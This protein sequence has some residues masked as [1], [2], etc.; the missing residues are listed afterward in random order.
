M[1][2]VEPPLP[3]PVAVIVTPPIIAVE[4]QPGTPNNGVPGLGCGE[5]PPPPPIVTGYPVDAVTG[6]TAPG[7]NNPPAPPPP[8]LSPPPPP[9]P[10]IT[11]TCTAP[12]VEGVV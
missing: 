6:I 12:T 5:P 10:A 2:P 4:L 7:F 9:P 8:P 11:A 1:S 3:P